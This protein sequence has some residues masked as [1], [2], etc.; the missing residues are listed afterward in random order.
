[1]RKMRSVP[2][3]YQ[4]KVEGIEVD[5]VQ[6]DIKNINLKIY[7]ANGKVRVSTPKKIRK[8]IIRNFLLD[9]VEWIKKHLNRIEKQLPAKPI[10]YETGEKHSLFGKEYSMILNEIKMKPFVE[11]DKDH[12]ILN[13]RPGSDEEQ[14]E[15]V[16]REWYRERMKERIPAMI[17]KY[18]KRLGVKAKEW[19]L[20]KMKTRWGTCNIRDSRV[21]FSL[22]LAKKPLI[23]LEY[24][25]LNELA[26]LIE[27]HHNKKFK[28]ILSREMPQ[29]REVECV[30]NGYPKQKNI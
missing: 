20:K 18:E 14:R 22:E 1:M 8:S 10:R 16:M 3:T 28:S 25:V 9:K 23:C 5:V 30:M 21:W 19:R 4:L 13:V 11:I 12:I 24:V 15:K 26:H 6:K 17:E 7:R 29:W 27:R 2:N